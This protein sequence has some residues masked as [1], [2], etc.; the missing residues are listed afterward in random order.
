MSPS[1][2]QI[3]LRLREHIRSL[4]TPDKRAASR[5]D[6]EMVKHYITIPDARTRTSIVKRVVQA[7]EKYANA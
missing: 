7:A 6:G 2:K 3:A 5:V 4:T 1:Q